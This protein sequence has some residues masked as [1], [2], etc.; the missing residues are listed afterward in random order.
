[1]TLMKR[2]L[3]SLIMLLTA[4]C[5]SSQA[6]KGQTEKQGG[7]PTGPCSVLSSG[8][9]VYDTTECEELARNGRLIQ[10]DKKGNLTALVLV[11][12]KTTKW[13]VVAKA[14]GKSI[15]GVPVKLTSKKDNSIVA[16]AV[17]DRKGMFSLSI[18][19]TFQGDVDSYINEG[20]FCFEF[21]Q[22][23]IVTIK[24]IICVDDGTLE[25]LK[26]RVVKVTRP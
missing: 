15:A 26:F 8:G 18:P 25:P 13:K 12:G 4:L 19:A 7:N 2:V 3:A 10:K 11:A 23:D 22:P 24:E 14:K 1:M 20:G 9:T 17:T 16:Q 6:Q 21:V 5:I